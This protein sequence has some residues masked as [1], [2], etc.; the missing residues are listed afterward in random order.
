M[1]DGADL[2]CESPVHLGWSPPATISFAERTVAAERLLRQDPQQSDRAVAAAT[3]LA[4][5][6]VAA[7]R[8][9]SGAP[10][11]LARIGR[12][13][14]VRPI[15]S[16]EGRRAAARYLRANPDATLRAIATASGISV[17][18][19]RDVRD[20]LRRGEHPVPRRR[21]IAT[22]TEPVAEPAVESVPIVLPRAAGDQVFAALAVLR[23]DPALRGM[24]EGRLLLRL[25]DGHAAITAWRR[26]ADIVP[27]HCAEMVL[28]LATACAERWSTVASSLDQRLSDRGERVRRAR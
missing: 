13:G 8:N 9:R 22:R 12:D 6:T 18:T 17:G 3:G 23:N 15:D 20:R 1:T 19:A 2:D 4:P 21:R 16:T 5:G 24:Q 28:E 10:A 26:V 25:L 11:V 7:I 14:R 27:P